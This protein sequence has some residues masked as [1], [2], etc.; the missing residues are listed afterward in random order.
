MKSWIL[1]ASLLEDAKEDFGL[2][3]SYIKLLRCGE[4]QKEPQ[5]FPLTGDYLTY[6]L[7]NADYMSELE[8]RG[9]IKVESQSRN[10]FIILTV[11]WTNAKTKTEE[12]ITGLIQ[13]AKKEGWTHP[14]LIASLREWLEYKQ[15]RRELYKI[16]SPIKKIV[17]LFEGQE[18]CFPISV[19]AAISANSMG[20]FP[21]PWLLKQRKEVE[22]ASNREVIQL[23]EEMRV[24]AEEDYGL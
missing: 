15:S 11:P 3:Y 9:Y 19:D 5:S 2:I 6:F 18:D 23:T 12:R 8:A 20:V 7:N 22:H 21:K 13:V 14:E 24:K 16:A 4:K 17:R 10:P 1:P